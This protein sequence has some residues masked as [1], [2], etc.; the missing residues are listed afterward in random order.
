MVYGT[1]VFLK[2]LYVRFVMRQIWVKLEC[3]L[4]FQRMSECSWIICRF[5][6]WIQLYGSSDDITLLILRLP[7][8]DPEL[9]KECEDWSSVSLQKKQVFN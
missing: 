4:F 5:Q 6:R 8:L 2:K 7:S 9:N 3:P 1:F